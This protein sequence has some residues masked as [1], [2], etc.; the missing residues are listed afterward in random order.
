MRKIIPVMFCIGVAML[1]LSGYL[2]YSSWQ[3]TQKALHTPGV[4]TDLRYSRSSDS[5]SGVWY[6]EV[7]FEDTTGQTITFESSVGSSSYRNSRGAKVDVIYLNGD[8]G[9]ARINNTTDMYFLAIFFALFGLVFSGVSYACFW[10]LNRR[11]RYRYLVKEG[12]P[13][14]AKIDGVELNRSITINGRSFW[15]IR[16]KW[17]DPLSRQTHIFYSENF[18]YNPLPYLADG[19]ITVYV[20]HDSIKKYYVDTAFLSKTK[21]PDAE[22]LAPKR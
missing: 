2:A 20:A 10:V 8:T 4:I 21:S 5:S 14:Q 18:A 19:P 13:L 3:F 7:T 16:C 22:V 9:S 17:L 11:R 6:P 12:K 15:Q 1:L